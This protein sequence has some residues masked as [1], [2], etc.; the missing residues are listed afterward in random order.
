MTRMRLAALAAFPVLALAVTASAAG[1]LV[2]QK[3]KQ[4]QPGDIRVRAG[5]TV[6]FRNDDSVTH[7]VMAAGGAD[8]FNL[9]AQKPGDS[10]EVTFAEPGQVPVICAIHPKMKMT[11]TVE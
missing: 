1:H 5:E 9:G 6:V 11:V 4:F 3:D 8:R 7:N 2:S 10:A